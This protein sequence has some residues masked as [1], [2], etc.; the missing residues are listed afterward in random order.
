MTEIATIDAEV[1]ERRGKGAARA[2]RRAALVPAVVYGDRKEPLLITVDEKTLR[3]ELKQ[4]G[5]FA[6]Q[7]DLR[8]NGESHRVLPRDVQ[9][10]PVTERPLHVDFLRVSAD[11]KIR[12]SVPVV[13]ENEEASPGLKRGGVLNVVRHEIEVFCAAGAI[14]QSFTVDL[15]GLD[16][17]DSVHISEIALPEGV[18]PTITD[19]DF[20][21]ATIAAPTVM[22]AEEE[23][24]VEEE[25]EVEEA[26]PEEAA[27]EEEEAAPKEEAES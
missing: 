7:F 22:P 14:P 20:T 24:V 6:R 13:F 10:H 18:R 11:T 5:F 17:G 15:S 21:I 1:R 26:A 25:E 19:R 4:P 12:L 9:L 2:A 27:P 23:A 3:R 8:L 16:I